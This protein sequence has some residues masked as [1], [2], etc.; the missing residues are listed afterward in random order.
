M[1]FGLSCAIELASSASWSQIW[2]PTCRRQVRAIEPGRRR[3]RSWSATSSRSGLQP[4]SELRASRIARGRPNSI[5]LSSSL[6]GRRPARE[7]VRQ[8]D[9]VMECGLKFIENFRRS[10]ATVARP[11]A[12][13]LV[14]YFY[15]LP[16]LFL[17]YLKR[18]SC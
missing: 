14:S 8:L 4:T 2:F 18:L 11:A 15:L 17:N 12:A 3:L 5:T 7:L 13:E 10:Q 6:A 1:E 9:R 16:I